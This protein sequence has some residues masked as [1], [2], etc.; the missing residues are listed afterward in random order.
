MG[1]RDAD[2][3][4]GFA[5][6]T[7]QGTGRISRNN[8]SSLIFLIDQSGSMNDA[9]GEDSTLKKADKVADIINRFLQALS[10][11]C[12]REDGVRDYYHVAC[13]AVLGGRC[14]SKYHHRYRRWLRRWAECQT[15]IHQHQMLPTRFDILVEMEQVCGIVL[16][17]QSRPIVGN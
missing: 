6:Q 13:I 11:K 9:W 10:I 16:V 4:Y 1:P 3:L 8:P 15:R 2:R 12:A 17:F 5:A 7:P 14:I